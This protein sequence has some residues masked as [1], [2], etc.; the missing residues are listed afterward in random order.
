MVASTVLENKLQI[1]RA[2][3]SKQFLSRMMYGAGPRIDA[4]CG[5]HQYRDD[6]GVCDN[7]QGTNREPIPLRE[8]MR[9]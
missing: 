1:M 2:E 5:R 3:T 4:E 6:N 8:V 7:C 9:V